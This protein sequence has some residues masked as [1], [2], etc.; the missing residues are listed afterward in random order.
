DNTLYAA[1]RNTVT[2]P[3]RLSNGLLRQT[4]FGLVPH[5]TCSFACEA[6]MRYAEKLREI[7]I[8]EAPAYA[9]EIDK[10]SGDPILSLSELRIYRFN[11]K[12]SQPFTVEY[13]TVESIY[14]SS[15][16]DL[17][18]EMLARGDMCRIEENCVRIYK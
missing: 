15:A 7:I 4:A 16:R 17:L 14:P 11:G 2:G 9:R 12:I 3:R 1:Y 6:S 8:E 13:D 10:R 18:Y 5:M